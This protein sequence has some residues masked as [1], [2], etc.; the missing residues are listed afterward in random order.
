MAAKRCPKCRRVHKP[1]LGTRACTGHLSRNHPTDPNG[2]CTMNPMDGQEVCGKHGGRSPQAIAAAEQRLAEEAALKVMRRFGGPI[3]TTP[4][5]ALLDTVKWTAGYVAWLR[6][7]VASISSD[8]K[9]VWGMTRRKSG[10]EDRGTTHESKPNVWLVLLGEWQ[11]RLVKVCAEAIKAG[12]E[13]RRV[14]LAEGQGAIV[15]Q[16]I[17]DILT[18][19]NLTPKQLALVAEVVPRHLRLVAS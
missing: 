1:R 7:Q 15:A 17:R 6:E 14:R 4:T 8:E 19:L 18:D 10:G 3:D 11:D 9:L 13:E 12:I 16:V 5:E 2:P